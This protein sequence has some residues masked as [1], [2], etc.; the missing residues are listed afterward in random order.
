MRDRQYFVYIMT[1]KSKT[2]IY[3]GMTNDLYGRVFQHKQKFVHGYTSQHNIDRLVYF[4]VGESVES[5][6]AR[7][8]QI[9]SWKRQKKIDLVN[10]VNPKWEDLYPVD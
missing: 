3:T 1:N 7:E 8:K 6:I 9:K 10:T 5:I 2:A 4:E